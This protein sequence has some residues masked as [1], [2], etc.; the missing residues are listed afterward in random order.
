MPSP[1][2]TIQSVSYRCIERY[3]EKGR[4]EERE[5]E[6]EKEKAKERERE[7]ERER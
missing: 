6:R 2:F 5:K 1:R 3:A 4:L 7:R